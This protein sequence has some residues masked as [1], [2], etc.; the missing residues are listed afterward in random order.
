M[1]AL[2][3]HEI[4]LSDTVWVREDRNPANEIE[5]DIGPLFVPLFLSDFMEEIYAETKGFGLK[6]GYNRMLS[7][8]FAAGAEFAFIT[9]RIEEESFNA[10]IGSIDAGVHGWYYPWKK[11]FYLRAGFGL[12]WFS[13]DID[14][15]TGALDDFKKNFDPY[16]GISGTFDVGFGWSLLLGGHFIIDTSI[17]S[18]LYIGD[19]LSAA[20][21]F[22]LASG[23]IPA[24]SER[25]FPLRFD[26]AIALGWAL[27]LRTV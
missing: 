14:G 3:I 9:A 19:A 23:A 24:L 4:P 21:L 2:T 10:A 16:I 1:P 5:V 12:A 11:F 15:S 7:G 17:V 18:G 26:A 6:A 8:H 20:T 25:G 13:F 27:T 22:K